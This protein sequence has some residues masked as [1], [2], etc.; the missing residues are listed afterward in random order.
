M[1]S[2]TAI[3]VQN[4]SKCYLIYDHPKDRLKQY[5]FPRLRRLAGLEPRKYYRE[6]W[7]LNDVSFEIPKGE[8]VGIIGRNG[9]GKST[10]LQ[11]ICGTLSP[12]SG[13]VNTQGRVA[14]LLELGSG[15]NP[16]FSGLEN[17]YMNAAVLGMSEDETTAKL[18]EIIAFA[19]IGDHLNQPTKT[20]SSGMAVRLAFAVQALSDP[21]IL[22]VDEALAVGDIKFQ[23]KCFERL[24][25]LKNRGTSILLVTHSSEQIVTHCTRAILI[26]QGKIHE[27]GSPKHVVN[28]YHEVIF[29][30]KASPT[31]SAEP[32]PAL[33]PGQVAQT[34]LSLNEDTFSSHPGYNPHEFRWG[35][36]KAKILDYTLAAG[37][38]SYPEHVDTSS[39]VVLKVAIRFLQDIVEPILGITIKTH[40]G[41]AVYGTNSEKQDTHAFTASGTAGQV[42]VVESR[43]ICHLAPGNYFISIGVASREKDEVVPHDRRYDAI[44]FQV[45]P[46]SNFYG[47]A[48]L[49]MELSAS[50]PRA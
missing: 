23:A 44:H 41:V 40:E 38:K 9:S 30:R 34:E 47:L 35:D 7:A 32:D 25:Q 8:T 20:Y 39:A 4:L 2:D 49:N 46:H 3:K 1:S 31:I 45:N 17:I 18:D 48:N 42:A 5:A 33:D 50:E 15:F 21:D 6:F 36:G 28:V 37:S 24:K 14:A 27:A 12:T 16:E 22:V 43:F 13:E 29:G 10:L 19:D 26:E 11:M